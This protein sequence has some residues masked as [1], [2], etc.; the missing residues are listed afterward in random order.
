MDADQAARLPG[1]VALGQMIEHRPG[2][3]LRQVRAEEGS[4]FAFGEAV[5][6]GPAV[7]Q[8][9]VIVLAEAAADWEVARTTQPVQRAVGA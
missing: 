2:L 9:D 7:E 5:F 6:A 1:A 4:A 3:V 8:A